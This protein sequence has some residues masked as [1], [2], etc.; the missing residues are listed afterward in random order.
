MDDI[1]T[2]QSPVLYQKGAGLF[3]LLRGIGKRAIPFIVKNIVPEALDMGRRILEDV[4]SGQVKL[5]ESL[6]D[7]GIKALRGVAR[8]AT[9]RGAGRVKKKKKKKKRRKE[10][11][12]TDVFT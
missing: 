5:K 12:K 8:R 4:S 10:C 9:V 6:K 1:T 3:S 7:R 11:Y 2:F